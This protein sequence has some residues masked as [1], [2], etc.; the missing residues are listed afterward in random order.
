MA[1]TIKGITVEI[2]GNTLG[3]QKA[4]ADVNSKSRSLQSELKQVEKL[5]KLD[6]SNTELL[7]QK[8]KL[9]GEAVNT[10]SEKLNSLKEAE[11]QV[12]NQFKEGKVSEEQ[13]RAL[14]REIVKTEQDLN[15]YEGQLREVTSESKKAGDATEDIGKKATGTAPSMKSFSTGAVLAIT[16]I[17]VAAVAA[18]KAAVDVGKKL[19]QITYD[20]GSAADDIVTMSKQFRVS[21]EDLQKFAYC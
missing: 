15:G 21:T 2:G 11:Q 1:A 10:T 20:A 5:L 7:A 16:A 4:L 6:P 17:S 8:Q 14:Q 13:Y 18:A 3:L 9:L 12:Q 19:Y